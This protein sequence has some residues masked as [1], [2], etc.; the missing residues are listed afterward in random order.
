MLIRLGPGFWYDEIV[1]RIKLPFHVV[2]AGR[3]CRRCFF[4]YRQVVVR[5]YF[6]RSLSLLHG[7]ALW[8]V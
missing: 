6:C 4:L 1:F 7:E 2:C 5:R 8:K 3:W